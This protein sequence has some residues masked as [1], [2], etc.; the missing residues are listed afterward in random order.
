MSGMADRL[1]H[2]PRT[3]PDLFGWME[4]GIPGLYTAPGAHGIRIEESRTE[5][6]YSLRA[7]LPGIDPAKDIDITVTGGVLTLCAERSAE[8]VD[9]SHSEFRYGS[10][11]RVVRLPVDARGEEATADYTDGV[12]TITV[13][14]PEGSSATRTIPVRH[15]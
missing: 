9:K 12:L 5:G 15:T 1:P 3:L 11:A 2:W 8:T 14:V 10:F 7:E 4:A 13:P 6:T